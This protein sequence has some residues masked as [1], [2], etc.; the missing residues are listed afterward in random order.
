MKIMDGMD[1]MDEEKNK[2]CPRVTGLHRQKK[3]GAFAAGFT[4]YS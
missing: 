2:H 3:A 4:E 1:G